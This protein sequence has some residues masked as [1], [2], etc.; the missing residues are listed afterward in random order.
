MNLTIT[1]LYS[2]EGCGTKDRGV[3]VT[4]RAQHE[5]VR[6]WMDQTVVRTLAKDH[7]A[8]HPTCQAT[9]MQ[10]IKVPM[11]GRQWVGGPAVN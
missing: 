5:D 1:V 10:E 6:V 4:C 3:A 8:R 2:C 11:S 9:V 7:R